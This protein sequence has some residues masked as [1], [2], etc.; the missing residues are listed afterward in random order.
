MAETNKIGLGYPD[1][2]SNGELTF[3]GVLNKYYY[4]NGEF[5]PISEPWKAESTQYQYINDYENRVLPN[6][7]T[8]KPLSQ[9]TE[10][11]FLD[12]LLRI[13]QQNS[14]TLERM[15]HYRYIMWRVYNA[16]VQNGLYED[17]IEWDMAK[18]VGLDENDRSKY[19]T[20]KRH[21]NKKAFSYE[22]SIALLKYFSNLKAETASGCDIGL[23]CMFLYGLRNNEAAALDFSSV[24]LLGE[25]KIPCI[26]VRQSALQAG[27]IA[28]ASGKTRN[29]NRIIPI[30]DV[31]Y[32]FIMRRRKYVE[33]LVEA[34]EIELNGQD[35]DVSKLPIASSD[36][37]FCKMVLPRD[38]SAVGRELFKRL[39]IGKRLMESARED[40]FMQKMQEAEVE[41]KD[42]TTYVFRRNHAT[43]LRCLG[44]N[45]IQ[46]QYLMG[47][48]LEE[49]TWQRSDFNN[50]DELMKIKRIL[51]KHPY[52]AYLNK[53]SI[54]KDIE[55]VNGPFC[56]DTESEVSLKLNGGKRYIIKVVADEPCCEI[57]VRTDSKGV[58]Q[59]NAVQISSRMEKKGRSTVNIR[60][61]VAKKYL[62]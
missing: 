47:H 41:E 11:D 36:F 30:F 57:K 6:I 20:A 21:L 62:I 5:E 10:E 34:G 35:K 49:T 39:N 50:E 3:V 45:D 60:D 13:K 8:R 40:I 26:I 48:E 28:K 22:E 9:F 27:R 15:Q 32:D 19:D 52:N 14:Y 1:K 29:A 12:S 18:L 31:T 42:A 51:E 23:L 59:C 16:G 7:N 61:K 44:L 53:N 25:S 55:L 33:A 54:S 24:R 43:R 56:L 38:L 2:A 17:Q 37:N 4:S 58:I 46:R